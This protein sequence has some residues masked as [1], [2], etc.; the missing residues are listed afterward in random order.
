MKFRVG[1]MLALELED[2][3]LA[4]I[5]A[6]YAIVNLPLETLP[7]A[8][9]DMYRVLQPGGVLFL[10]FHVGDE[11]MEE[12]ELWGHKLNMSFYLLRPARISE[13]LVDSGFKLEEMVEREPYPEVEYPSRR[14][15]IFA[16]K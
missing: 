16:S 9:G 12:E 2:N 8:F 10:S 6:F 4:G 11:K 15:Y 5:V 14:A 7:I 3:S 1:D 13:L